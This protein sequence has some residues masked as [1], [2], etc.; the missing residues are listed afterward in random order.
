MG[1]CARSAYIP[2]FTLDFTHSQMWYDCIP[3]VFAIKLGRQRLGEKLPILIQKV[4]LQHPNIET[5]TPSLQI[6]KKPHGPKNKKKYIS[7]LR[8]DPDLWKI[9]PR[10][11]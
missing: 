10:I 5:P 11:F 8:F 2:H 7:I 6:G 4:Q 9:S 1:G 3:K